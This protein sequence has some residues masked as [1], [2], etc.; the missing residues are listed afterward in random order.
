MSD[1][2]PTH[3]T[4]W[5]EMVR[6]D[7]SRAE[8][9]FRR[10]SPELLRFATSRVGARRG[11]IRSEPDDIVQECFACML[12]LSQPLRLLHQQI[13]SPDLLTQLLAEVTRLNS[14]EPADAHSDLA[15]WLTRILKHQLRPLLAADSVDA[16]RSVLLQEYTKR[17]EEFPLRAWLFAAAKSKLSDGFRAS[18]QTAVW[19]DDFDPPAAPLPAATAESDDRHAGLAHC[20]PKLSDEDRSLL[21]IRFSGLNSDCLLQ[22]PELLFE[23]QELVLLS[24]SEYWGNVMQQGGDGGI[25][26]EFV[27]RS[28]PSPAAAAVAP[29][30]SGG[31]R[32]VLQVTATLTAVLVGAVLLWRTIPRGWEDPPGISG[33]GLGTRDLFKPDTEN[34][35]EY[36]S[37]MAAAVNSL[38]K[39]SDLL[40][41]PQLVAVLQNTISDCEIAIAQ[42]HLVLS[43]RLLANGQAA[44]SVFRARC[45]AWKNK[46]SETLAVLQQGT[47]DVPAAAEATTDTL[48][49]L[50]NRLSI[51][52]VLKV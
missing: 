27:L 51:H 15:L 23:L 52:A 2:L 31:L 47:I 24:D 11:A 37:R 44:E 4:I 3:D 48:Q 14:P 29:A 30:A 25:R 1:S 9:L 35:D 41:W 42:L 46:L 28:R 6:C 7:Q 43:R 17:T 16:F 8:I 20:L 5:E 39:E 45:E 40:Q 33:S 10:H 18:R 19:D 49:K 36:L 38:L 13:S 12:Q 34:A 21:Q 32:R 26:Q 50:I 22:N